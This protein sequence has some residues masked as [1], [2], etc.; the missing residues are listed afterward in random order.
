MPQIAPARPQRTSSGSSSSSSSRRRSQTGEGTTAWA[1]R[2]PLGRDCLDNPWVHGSRGHSPQWVVVRSSDPSQTSRPAKGRS[3]GPPDCLPHWSSPLPRP[4]PDHIEPAPPQKTLSFSKPV[5]QYTSFFYN[6]PQRT[7]CR[8][9][10]ASLQ[11]RSPPSRSS[12]RAGDPL[13]F[14]KT[15][16]WWSSP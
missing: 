6:H 16:P 5:L 3:P 8:S 4:D 11:S 13:D 1:A 14:P 2:D 9:A 15:P 7:A 12:R 10:K